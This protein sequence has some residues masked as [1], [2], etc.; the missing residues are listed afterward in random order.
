MC[1]LVAFFQSLDFCSKPSLYP[2]MSS[3]YLSFFLSVGRD[4]SQGFYE[5]IFYPA[6]NGTARDIIFRK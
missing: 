2:L 1:F 4:P 3:K 6:Q 5:K